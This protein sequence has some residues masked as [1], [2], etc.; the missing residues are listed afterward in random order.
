MSAPCETARQAL[1][2]LVAEMGGEL[3][4]EIKTISQRFEPEFKRIEEGAP[5]TGGL[6]AAL[7]LD[8]DIQ[9]ETVAIAL[10]LPEVVMKL[11]EWKLDLPQ[12]TMRDKRIVFHTPSARMVRKKIG[13]Y[14][15]VHGWKIKWRDIFVDVPE[16]FMQE[17]VII[18]GIPEVRMDTTSIKLHIPEFAMRTQTLKFDVPKISVKSI[19]V[20]AKELEQEANEL[21]ATMQ[22][23]IAAKRSQVLGT[24]R[25]RI[26]AAASTLFTCLRTQIQM[27]RDEAAAMFEPGIA[28]FQQTLSKLQSAGATEEA[29]RTRQRLTELLSRKEEAFRQFDEGVRRIV[30]EEKVTVDRLLRGLRG[31][32]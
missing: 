28:M 27:K 26:V 31:E 18:V 29:E 1:Y 13:Q 15:E 23:E 7:M 20:E 5:D 22:Q 16:F 11:Q 17:H 14:P 12:V 8:I 9:W 4:R 19:R 30:D 25:D 32:A 3:S 10:D 6:D 2:D 21:A 24:G